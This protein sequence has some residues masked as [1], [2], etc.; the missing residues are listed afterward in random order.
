MTKSSSK[1][2]Y[3][4]NKGSEYFSSGTLVVHFVTPTSL[5][6]GDSYPV[7]GPLRVN[8]AN[9]SETYREYDVY[10][11]GVNGVEPG[12]NYYIKFEFNG[13]YASREMELNGISS[14]SVKHTKDCGSKY[15]MEPGASIHN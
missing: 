9:P 5:S 1:C 8:Q 12:T 10:D 14:L 13:E 15:C 3:S 4:M 11:Y 7:R 6:I 2:Y